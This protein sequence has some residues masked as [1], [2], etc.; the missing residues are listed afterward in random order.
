MSTEGIDRIIRAELE[1][2]DASPEVLAEFDRL[3][4][5]TPTRLGKETEE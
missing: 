4:A 5:S 2:N 3:A 1:M